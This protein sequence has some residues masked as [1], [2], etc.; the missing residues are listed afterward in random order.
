MATAIVTGGNSGIGRATAVMLAERGFDVG[1]TFHADEEQ[2]REAAAECERHGARTAVR[3]MDLER[4]V[5]EAAAADELAEEL[6][7]VDVFVNNA[8]GAHAAPVLELTLEDWSAT[9]DLD[10]T[11]AF[12]CL[13]RA[14]RRMV[15][16]GRGG[17]LIAVTSIHEHLPLRDSA[18]Y[19]A[20]KG[21][22][23]M[24]MKSLALELGE[25]GIT[26]NAVAP[27]EIATKMTGQEDEDPHDEPRPGIPLGRPG[28][29][30]EIAEA[31]AFLASEGASYATGRSFIIDGG[32]LLMAPVANQ[33]DD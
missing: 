26:A 1:I 10:L 16:Q 5:T 25:H 3:N 27:G 13:Q 21:G 31:V 33:P 8:G 12:L 9:L 11:G 22:L 23:G 18:A 30:R 15:D 2:A 20:A 7:G 29:A 32:M 17:R 6:G 14:A 24:L 19:G 4:D 28:H